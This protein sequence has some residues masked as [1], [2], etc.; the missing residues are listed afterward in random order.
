MTEAGFAVSSLQS[1]EHATAVSVAS[2][3][4]RM[5]GEAASLAIQLW[6]GG[7]DSAYALWR[8][9]RGGEL[10]VRALVTTVALGTDRSTWH[11]VRTDL[12][13]RQASAI[14]LPLHEVVV[15]TLEPVEALLDAI[16]DFLRTPAAAAF[17]VVVWGDL[18]WQEARRQH[19]RASADAGK[20]GAYPL[21]MVGRDTAPVA[22]AAV[23]AGFKA[24]VTSVDTRKLDP[25]FCG[26]AY[27][28]RF[29]DDLPAEVDPCG[30]RG[31]FHTFV[32]D[33]PIFRAPVRVRRT[34]FA[35]SRTHVYCDLEPAE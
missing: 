19:E 24:V 4:G 34:R 11:G 16:S 28:D 29:L 2:G 26:R 35:H 10:D 8:T 20:R 15:P 12:M 9:R 30:E 6:S 1:L 25:G 7:K 33:G 3:G 14:G 18:Y 23:A 27:D 13:R 5:L 21:W 32:W 31:E 22:R 17:P